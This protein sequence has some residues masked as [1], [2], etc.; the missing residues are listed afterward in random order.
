MD[1]SDTRIEAL[2]DIETLA[3]KHKFCRLCSASAHWALEGEGRKL[4]LC[5]TC[6]AGIVFSSFEA[7]SSLLH[8]K[9]AR[10]RD[11]ILYTLWVRR[12]LAVA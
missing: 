2:E 1:L 8:G 12:S 5:D 3:D 10:E 6:A 4:L 7:T 11:T 9:S